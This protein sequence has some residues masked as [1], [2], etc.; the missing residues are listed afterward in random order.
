MFRHRYLPHS[1]AS[2]PAR[3]PHRDRN[4]WRLS[5]AAVGEGPEVPDL[6]V[7]ERGRAFL[8]SA[9]PVGVEARVLDVAVGRVVRRHVGWAKARL[10]RAHHL[11]ACCDVK[12]WARL[13]FAHPTKPRHE[14]DSTSRASAIFRV[15]LRQNGPTVKSFLIIGND[16][17]PK[18]FKEAKINLSPRRANQK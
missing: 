3:H 11:S 9:L 16:V 7:P 5:G 14:V 4:P 13:R 12:W 17:K 15:C 18:N 10:R 6:G 8:V 2:H 1:R